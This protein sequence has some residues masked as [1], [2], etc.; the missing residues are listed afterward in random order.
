MNKT[1]LNKDNAW[2]QMT[3]DEALATLSVEA[4][5]GLTTQQASERLQTYG[6]NEII[7]Q[8]G[9]SIWKILWAQLTDTMVLVLFGAAIISV[10][11]SDWKDA[12]AI[13][14]IVLINAIIGLV[15]EYRAEQAMAC[16][17]LY[18]CTRPMMALMSTM[19]KMAIASFQS[20]ISTEMIAAP[21]KTSTMVSVSCAQR[22]FQML[23]PP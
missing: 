17:A 13:F 4:K 15:Q 3:A 14:A 23:L 6:K 5:N 20:L 1:I 12:I 21:N 9:K 10:L 18:S 2:Y 22:I 19:A 11:I 7:D 16:S 8:G